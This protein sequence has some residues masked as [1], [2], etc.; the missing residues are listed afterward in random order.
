M[1]KI[2]ISGEIG[3]DYTAGTIKAE[4]RAA[5][6]DDL[7]IDVASPGGDVFDGIEIYNAIRDYKRDYP[8]AQIHMALKG[9]GASM[10]SYIMMA[11]AD[12]RTAEDNAVFMIHNPWS[13]AVGD[14]KEMEKQSEFL[15]GLA[16]LMA[17]AYVSVTGK[18]KPEIQAM[19]DAETWMF[20]SEMKDAGFVS[21]MMPS[22]S[23]DGAKKD[24]GQ[25]LALARGSFDAMKRHAQEKT[26][27]NRVAA[28]V[29]AAV[30]QSNTSGVPGAE[31]RPES[32][33]GKKVNTLAELKNDAPSVYAEASQSFAK[34]E[35]ERIV[36]VLDI[37][38]KH[39]DKVGAVAELCDKAIADG[40]TASDIAVDVLALVTAALESPPAI[41]TGANGT[42]SGE[43]APN[44]EAT[45]APVNGYRPIPVIQ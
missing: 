28:M 9:L 18:K 27:T 23:D 29:R 11:P 13:L 40:R 32:K 35:R 34:A 36:A 14:Y 42:A 21:D 22:E 41:N 31:N 20:G 24:K 1:K 30:E 16:S 25:A 37:K 17:D 2:S 26:D 39:G 4:L 7:E 44:A 45:A 43:Q 15:S 6:G 33:G 5:K 3:W 12:L 10:A 38:K 8:N 19:M